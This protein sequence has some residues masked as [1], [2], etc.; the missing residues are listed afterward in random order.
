MDP[1]EYAKNVFKTEIM[2]YN[3]IPERIGKPGNSRLLHAAFG[4]STEANEFMDQMKK[5]IFYDKELDVKNL[6]E[7]LGDMLWYITVAL[8]SIGESMENCMEAN[9]RKLF[10][11]YKDKKFTKSEAHVRN[12][13]KEML[14]LEGK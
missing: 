5:H 3:E 11:R 6:F 14:N 13:E 9:I 2:D 1:K 4:L 12:I 8:D 10:T 7:E